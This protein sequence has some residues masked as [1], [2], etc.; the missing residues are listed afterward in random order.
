MRFVS[1]CLLAVILFSL[2]V[3]GGE[4]PHDFASF[5]AHKKLVEGQYAV[6]VF[7]DAFD[8]A[9]FSK[10]HSRDKHSEADILAKL[11]KEMQE[12]KER[13][14]MASVSL[15]S[16]LLPCTSC[17]G[18]LINFLAEH[19]NDRR[20]VD[21]E[22][23]IKK[24]LVVRYPYGTISKNDKVEK[25]VTTCQNNL[26]HYCQVFSSVSLEKEGGIN[27]CKD[28]TFCAGLRNE[29]IR[30]IVSSIAQ[31]KPVAHNVVGEAVSKKHISK[32]SEDVELPPRK[33]F[34]PVHVGTLKNEEEH[35]SAARDGKD[36]DGFT[37]VG[38]EVKRFHRQAQ[39]AEKK[40]L[41]AEKAQVAK[42][43][44]QPN[45]YLNFQKR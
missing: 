20:N 21:D 37:V 44:P 41:V 12:N 10:E 33:I 39:A 31:G 27:L 13:T 19:Y 3:L 6:L 26:D 36:A 1:L 24:N 11:Q 15:F 9:L 34:A 23:V 4:K 2:E 42:P 17:S 40:A 29:K 28:S 30:Q 7:D 18:G 5:A 38:R 8:S 22:P 25:R 45:R 35:K 14:P 32:I 16:V 43:K